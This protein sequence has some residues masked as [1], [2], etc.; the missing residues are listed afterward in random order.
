MPKTALGVAAACFLALA[1]SASAEIERDEDEMTG[2]TYVGVKLTSEDGEASLHFG[3]A[4]RSLDGHAWPW[5][6][7]SNSHFLTSSRNHFAL[8]Y[9]IDD[10]DVKSL[11][12]QA[13]SDHSSGHFDMLEMYRHEAILGD[14][15]KQ[16]SDANYGDKKYKK[17][18]KKTG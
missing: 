3:C 4:G 13:S 10:G 11:K 5:I 9:K 15:P 2:G 16:P 8:S 6:F 18:G 1:A 14:A 17:F 7:F 12:F